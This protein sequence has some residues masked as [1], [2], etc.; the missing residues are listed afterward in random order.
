MPGRFPSAFN[1]Q[2]M[3]THANFTSTNKLKHRN[4]RG[5][6]NVILEYDA[7]EMQPAAL[8]LRLIPKSLMY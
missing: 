4:L 2:P 6:K 1:A 7:V 3:S 8:L 5:F